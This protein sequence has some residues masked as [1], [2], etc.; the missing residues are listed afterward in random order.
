MI[1]EEVV[2]QRRVLEVL[3]VP[4][5]A[6]IAT[7]RR[8][9]LLLLALLVPQSTREAIVECRGGLAGERLRIAT[10]LQDGRGGPV[11]AR[12]SATF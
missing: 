1:L 6:T 10:M 2:F 5:A 8:C 3:E 7:L 12:Q 4:A 9:V 11:L